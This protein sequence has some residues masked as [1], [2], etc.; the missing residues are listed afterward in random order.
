MWQ[1]CKKSML[2][3]TLILESTKTSP[4]SLSYD[5][6]AT[7]IL[8]LSFTQYQRIVDMIFSM[9]FFILFLKFLNELK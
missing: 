5:A 7:S 1:S 8:D 2:L 4:F 9:L 3:N 6:E